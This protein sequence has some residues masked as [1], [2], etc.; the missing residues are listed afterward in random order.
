VTGFG[1]ETRRAAYGIL[2]CGTGIGISIAANK[3][4]GIRAAVCSDTYAAKCTR[5]HNDANVLC[6]GARVI[7][8]GLAFDIVDMFLETEFEGERH[9]RRLAQIETLTG[10]EAN[11]G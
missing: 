2:L 3:M 10:G 4:Q 7:G 1:G 5:L 11:D 6:L 9:M 8:E